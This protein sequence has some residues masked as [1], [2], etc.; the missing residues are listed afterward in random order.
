M[1]VALVHDHLIQDGGA[2]RVLR[3]FQKIFPKAPTY[4]LVYDKKKIGK[5]FQDKDIRT[6]F[7]QKFPFGVKKF[8]WFL[9]LMPLATE[10][11][12]LAD[13]D[14]V[15]SNS[16]ALSKGVITRPETLHICYCHTPTRYLWTDTHLYVRKLEYNRLI[17]KIISLTLPKLR[18]WDRMAAARVDKFI[19]NSKIVQKRIIKYYGRESEVIYPPVEVSKFKIYPKQENYFLAGGRLVPYK[20][21][22]LIVQA[23]GKLG[24]PLKIFGDG[25]EYQKLKSIAKSNIDFLGK[26]SDEEKI[27]LYGKCLAFIHPQEED[28]GLMVV[29]AMSAGRPVIAYCRGGACETIMSGKTGE[30]FDEQSWE[31]LAHTIIRFKPENYNSEAIRAHAMQ[32]DQSEFERK[33][34]EYIE[35]SW[36]EFRE[37]I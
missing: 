10:N 28:F 5:E 29:E 4:V 7:I 26:I 8:K 15:L 24:I 25:P 12:N 34:K 16:S 18:I 30:F 21:F 27:E 9:P 31:C 3:V 6:S 33:I 37:Q 13:Y 22:D 23:F 11:Y 2:E 36:R 35:K 20:R 32:F 14:I 17:K 1:K 19:A